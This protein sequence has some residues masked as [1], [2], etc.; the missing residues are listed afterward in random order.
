MAN[1]PEGVNPLDVIRTST[2]VAGDLQDLMRG[3]ELLV[4]RPIPAGNPRASVSHMAPAYVGETVTGRFTR[5]GPPDPERERYNVRFNYRLGFDLAEPDASPV[6]RADYAELERRV[7]SRMVEDID[8]EVMRAAMDSVAPAPVPD[9]AT[10]LRL[11]LTG[12]GMEVRD[13]SGRVRVRLGVWDEDTVAPFPEENNDRPP[14]V[15]PP[16]PR[17][18]RRRQVR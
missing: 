16:L 15:N 6:V 14:P 8:R 9:A 13:A 3:A 17:R 12:N 5:P 1:P 10:A 7:I 4:P 11:S 2:R 18:G